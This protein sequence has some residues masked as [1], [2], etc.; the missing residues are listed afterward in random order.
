MDIALLDIPLNAVATALKSFFM[1]LDKPL[2]HNY[3]DL[4]ATA[5]ISVQEERLQ[6][7]RDVLLKLKL[8]NFEVCSYLIG[9]LHKWVFFI[10]ASFRN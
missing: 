7:I 5:D 3:E 9:H 10:N 2:I 4:L 6:A 1:E 8:S